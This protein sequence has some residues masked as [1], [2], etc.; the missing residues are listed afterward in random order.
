M[1]SVTWTLGDNLENL[2]LSGQSAINATGNAL[3]NLLN[4]N[5]AANTLAGGAGNDIYLVG[6]GDTVVE[7]VGAGTDT[8]VSATSWT[9]GSNIEYLTLTGTNAVNGTGNALANNIRGNSANNTL[10]GGGGADSLFGGAGNDTL[11]GGIGNDHMAGGTGNDTYVVNVSTDVVMEGADEG[12]DTVLS[13][14]TLRLG[15]NIENLTLIG[16]AAI[17]GAGNM[18]DNLLVGN[19]A[20]NLLTG[21][22]GSD[23]YDGRGGSDALTD[24]S[25]TSGDYY[26]WGAGSGTDTITDRGGT[27]RVDIGSGITQGQLVFTRNGYDL[28]L[29][30]AGLADKL[31]VNNWY[32]SA[33]NQVEEFRLSNGNS[34]F[35]SEIQSLVSAMAVFSASQEA[36]VGTGRETILPMRQPDPLWTV[37]AVM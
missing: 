25:M 22:A 16:A 21:A 36:G 30:L 11:N 29:T 9:L 15:N 28:E 34:V 5:S 1:S 20:A 17:N 19:G 31:I 26:R 23:T 37:P 10:N 27:D 35:A 32:L 2:I 3:D 18:L 6:M 8:V 12:I 14:D 4:G 24:L 33:A 7:A 13:S